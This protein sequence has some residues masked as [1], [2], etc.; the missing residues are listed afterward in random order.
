MT[1]GA[2]FSPDRSMRFELW[3]DFKYERT[4]G[5]GTANFI[6]LN[7]SDADESRDDMTVRKDVGFARRWGLSGIV[8]TN[9]I[10][11]VSTDPWEL[12]P[13]RGRFLKNEKFLERNIRDCDLVVCSWGAVPVAIRRRVA[14]LEHLLVIRQMLV[15]YG[16]QAHCIGLTAAGFPMHPSRTAYTSAPLVFDF[17]EAA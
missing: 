14:L 1:R 15:E 12:P 8:L 3:R 6:S 9:A 16:K 7:P 13:W 10:P 17:P 4:T 5:I 11:I 2:T